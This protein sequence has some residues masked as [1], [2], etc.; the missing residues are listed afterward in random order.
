[1]REGEEGKGEGEGRRAEV[2]G[3]ETGWGEQEQKAGEDWSGER[4]ERERK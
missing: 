3:E 2:R 4:R 1:M